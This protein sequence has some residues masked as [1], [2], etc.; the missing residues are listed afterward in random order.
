MMIFDFCHSKK[1]KFQIFL[2]GC[3][4]CSGSAV[5]VFVVMAKVTFPKTD[6]KIQVNNTRM[7]SVWLR[8]FDGSRQK[9]TVRSSHL[10]SSD[11]LSPDLTTLI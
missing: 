8:G 6:E 7:C 1:N 5:T 9:E 2:F 10:P 4:S 3:S 11:V